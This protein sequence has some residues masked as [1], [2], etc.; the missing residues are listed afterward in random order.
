MLSAA[1]VKYFSSLK[2]KKYREKENKFLIEGFHLAEECLNSPYEIEC[3]VISEKAE[4]KKDNRIFGTIDKKKIPF[5]ILN[6]KSF[7]KLAETESSQGIIAVVKQKKPAPFSSLN[8]EN[9]IVALDR[10]TDPGNLGT[11]MRTAYWFGVNTVLV[12]ENSVDIYNSKVIRS[13]QGAQFHVNINDKLKLRD[14]LLELNESGF[15]VYLL[16]V[17]A[18]RM[19]ET[20][21]KKEKS[22]FVFGNESEGVSSD[23]LES[24][25]ERVKI[26]G[27]SGCESLNVA[28][29]C[30]IVLF[31]F[32]S[33]R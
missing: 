17:Q 5:H 11:I 28:V 2:Q 29:S 25:F 24:G 13:T 7:R 12:S 21:D 6:E 3:I 18:G 20:V 1:D 16:D 8:K 23:L 31:D 32:K 4:R 14:S 10:I 27:Y 22:V 9:L 15:K 19:L 26:K 30:G 33:S